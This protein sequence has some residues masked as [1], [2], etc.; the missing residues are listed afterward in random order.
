VI[1]AAIEVH[2]HLGPGLLESSYHACLCQELALRGIHYRSKVPLTLRYK[3]VKVG[4]GYVIDLIV[5]GQ[6]II[7]I[8]SVAELLPIH[9]AQLMTYLRLQ[10][11]TSGLLIN[12]NVPRLAQGI[13]RL[14]L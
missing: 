6:L 9:S 13:K 2:C 12:F 5:E 1:G 8:K 3:G 4:N 10:Q 7:E 11:C 14:L